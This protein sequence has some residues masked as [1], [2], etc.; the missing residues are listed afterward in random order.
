MKLGDPR[1]RLIFVVLGLWT[2]LSSSL[3]A[4]VQDGANLLLRETREN[5]TQMAQGL[6]AKAGVYFLFKTEA[7][8]SLIDFES[9]VRR[10]FANFIQGVPK[11]RGVLLYLQVEEGTRKGRINFSS[12]YGLRGAMSL[13]TVRSILR[14]QILLFRQD[15]SNQ[16]SLVGGIRD[17]FA[18]LEEFSEGGKWEKNLPAEDV[19]GL[20]TRGKILWLLMILFV[21]LCVVT[22]IYVYSKGKCPRCGSRVHVNFRP[23]YKR[24]SGYKRIKI[25]KCFDCNYFRKY[26][27]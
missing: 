1:S 20:F 6:K 19:N 12:G 22:V 18:L 21:S 17:Y 2:F 5:I 7:K 26:L 15:L 27:F 11:D 25:I 8:P 14:D 10:E 9:D 16:T 3:A 24:E 13:E 23:L 4:S